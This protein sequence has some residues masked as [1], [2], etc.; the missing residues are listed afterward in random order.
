M[1]QGRATV[2]DPATGMPAGP[3]YLER[4]DPAQNRARFY[5]L[6]VNRTLFA[7]EWVLVRRWGRI[8]TSGSRKEEWFPSL[9]DALTEQARIAARKTGRGYSA[10]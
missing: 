5:A 1:M 8:G 9:A 7:G 3:V 4:C 10:R 2:L 6:A